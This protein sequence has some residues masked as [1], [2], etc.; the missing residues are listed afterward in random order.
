MPTIKRFKID[1]LCIWIR[2]RPM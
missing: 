1:Y 2:E